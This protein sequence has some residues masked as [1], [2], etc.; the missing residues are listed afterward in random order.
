MAG[1]QNAVVVRRVIDE[2]WNGADLALADVLF[3]PGYV[4]HEG[5]IPDAVRG[6]EA[7]KI[8]VALYRTAFPHLHVTV[9]DLVAH[10]ETVALR[11]TARGTPPPPP[12]G[13]TRAA[14]GDWERA[15]TG[16]TLSHLCGGQIVE[17]WTSWDVLGALRRLGVLPADPNRTARSR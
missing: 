14:A 13:R 4:N 8:S 3:A 2:I 6:P 12:T 1:E 7:I 17:S 11:W 9:E 15:L 10:G 5:V 16:I